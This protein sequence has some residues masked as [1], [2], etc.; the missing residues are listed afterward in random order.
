MHKF[1][2]SYIDKLKPTGEQYEISLGFRLFV[3]VSAKGVKSYRYK[4]TDLTTKARK[5]KNIASADTMKLSQ[6]L[7]MAFCFNRL[8]DNGVEP[9]ANMTET[10]DIIKTHTLRD[11]VDDWRLIK[12]QHLS[13]KHLR[14]RMARFNNHLFPILG[15]FHIAEI[16]LFKARE[17]IKPIYDKAPHMGEKI[18][19]GEKRA[20]KRGE[21][22]PLFVYKT[23]N[24]AL[25]KIFL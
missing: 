18:A 6:A 9:F 11:I 7:E 17:L 22:S 4:Y 19:K 25:L 1:T 15:D 8:L 2:Q 12:G 20:P 14:D 5:K 24:K 10:N 21:E 13:Q 16:T 3:V 23:S